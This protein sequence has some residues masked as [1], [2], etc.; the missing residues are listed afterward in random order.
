MTEKPKY[1]SDVFESV[2][3]K[4]KEH[5]KPHDIWIRG[6][7]EILH[8]MPCMRF[9]H[10]NNGV[11]VKKMRAYPHEVRKYVSGL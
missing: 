11:L 4:F 3:F 8:C 1:Y 7:E 9:T 5:Q 6:D 10:Y 2:G